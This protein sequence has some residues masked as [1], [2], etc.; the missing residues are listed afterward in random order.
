MRTLVWLLLMLA[1]ANVYS[2][3]AS[4]LPSKNDRVIIKTQ[5]TVINRTG[6]MV[7][8]NPEKR[9]ATI[10]QPL[11]SGLTPAVLTKLRSTVALKNVFGSSLQDYK[12]DTWLDEFSFEVHH[13]QNHLLDIAFT[14]SG[15]GA[16]PDGETKH[17]VFD[18]NTGLVVKASQL[19]KQNSLPTLA[20]MINAKLQAEIKQTISETGEEGKSAYESQE[21]LVFKTENLD[22]FS[23][24]S[25]GITF[26]YDAGF[27]HVIQALE[28][29]GE[30]FFTY[31]ELKPYIKL[32]GL[33]GQFVR[34]R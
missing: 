26:L 14:Q 18:L 23:V 30:Y 28:P 34:Q 1:T 25:K 4:H 15:S 10:V 3:T 7:R 13:N 20:E 24:S 6:S 19:F 29:D 17:F 31:E 33:L 32:D 2:Q 12:S 22:N 5:R 16:Y 27:P 21:S 11:F 9:T 8:Q